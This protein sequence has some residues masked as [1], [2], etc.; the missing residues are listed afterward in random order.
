[1]GRLE[2]NTL[3]QFCVLGFGLSQDGNLGVGVFPEGEEIF[4]GGAA[5][6]ALNVGRIEMAATKEGGLLNSVLCGYSH[7]YCRPMSRNTLPLSTRHLYPC[8]GPALMNI[9]RLS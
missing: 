8:I 4:V 7:F 2:V 3:L 6:V 5:E 1:M 9:H